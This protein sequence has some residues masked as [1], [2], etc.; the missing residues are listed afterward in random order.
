MTW[1]SLKTLLKLTKKK[2]NLIKIK[3]NKVYLIL[4]PDFISKEFSSISSKQ[5]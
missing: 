5:K 4:N 1:E 3:K 2:G